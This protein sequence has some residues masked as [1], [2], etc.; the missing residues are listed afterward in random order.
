MSYMPSLDKVG[1]LYGKNDG[2][3]L[4]Q[5]IH[6]KWISTWLVKTRFLLLMWWL[7]TQHKIQWLCVSLID[8]QMQLWNLMPL[9]RTISIKGMRGTIL[10]WCQWKCTTHSGMIWIISSRNVSVFST[11]DDWEVIY[12]YIFAF[13]FQVAC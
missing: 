6:Y 12:P 1:M 9:L 3:P 2:T 13:N 4:R 7:L 11:I 5:E 10:F 8:Q